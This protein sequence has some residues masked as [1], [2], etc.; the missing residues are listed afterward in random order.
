MSVA[1]GGG[2]ARAMWCLRKLKHLRLHTRGSGRDYSYIRRFRSVQGGRELKRR[3]D[4]RREIASGERTSGYETRRI[5]AR[6]CACVERERR[7]G[8]VRA[9][10][11]KKPKQAHPPNLAFGGGPPAEGGESPPPT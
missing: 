1:L 6:P 5:C 7:R 11:S 3:N 2:E 10:H 4:G 8:L 9:P